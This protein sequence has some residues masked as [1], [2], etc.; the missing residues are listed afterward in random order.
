MLS[1]RYEKSRCQRTFVLS[2][3]CGNAARQHSFTPKNKDVKIWPCNLM[4]IVGGS[5][6]APFQKLRNAGPEKQEASTFHLFCLGLRKRST[7]FPLSQLMIHGVI[8][9]SHGDALHWGL[10]KFDRVDFTWPGGLGWPFLGVLDWFG[11]IGYR[12]KLQ[13]QCSLSL[14]TWRVPTKKIIPIRLCGHLRH[15]C[16][17]GTSSARTIQRQKPSQVACEGITTHPETIKTEA[18]RPNSSK[19]PP[20]KPFMI[21]I[22]G[23]KKAYFHP[24]NLLSGSQKIQ[25]QELPAKLL[26][27]RIG[28]FKQRRERKKNSLPPGPFQTNAASNILNSYPSSVAFLN[29]FKTQLQ[30]TTLDETNSFNEKEHYFCL[31]SKTAWATMSNTD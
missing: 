8:V 2:W 17:K 23:S 26:W 20:K 14:D 19:S 10:N 12:E 15:G 3:N 4:C 5:C 11:G 9:A 16:W 18:S 25:K 31:N 21:P 29:S 13:I 6:V 28:G 22:H 1:Q 27:S 7:F 30:Q 24:K